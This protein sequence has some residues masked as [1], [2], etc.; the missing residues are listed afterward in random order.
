MRKGGGR[1]VGNKVTYL[2][3]SKV[4]PPAMLYLLKVPQTYQTALLTVFKC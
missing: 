4:L 3:F 2:N 1:G